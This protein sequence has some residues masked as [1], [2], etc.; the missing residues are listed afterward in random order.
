MKTERQEDFI[1]SKYALISVHLDGI[2]I[3]AWGI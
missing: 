3:W 1:L 2:F